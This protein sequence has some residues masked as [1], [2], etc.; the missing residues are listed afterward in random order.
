M[1]SCLMFLKAE[2][3]NGEGLLSAF[4]KSLR[5]KTQLMRDSLVEKR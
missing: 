5:E 3:E 4:V 2:K 1:L